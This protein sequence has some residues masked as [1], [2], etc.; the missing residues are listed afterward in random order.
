MRVKPIIILALLMAGFTARAQRAAPGSDTVLKGSTIEVIQSYKPRVKQSPKPEWKPQLPPVDTSRP[1]FS[2][3]VPQQTLYYT[4]NSPPLR[5]LALGK[6]LNELPYQSYVK[7]GGGNRST[8]YADLGTGAIHGEDYETSIHGHHISQEGNIVNQQTSLSGLELAGAK[9]NATGDL[10]A[11]LSGS[12]NR[13]YYYGYDHILHNYSSESVSQAYTSVQL[14]ADMV[15]RKDTS[16]KLDYHPGI[17]ASYY[18]AKYNTNEITASFAA[19]VTYTV[20]KTLALAVNL[21]GA[22]T[23]YKTGGISTANN[24]VMAAPGLKLQFNEYYS[25]HALAGVAYGKGGNI[26]FLPDAEVA[27]TMKDYL[28]KL[29]LGWKANLRQNTYEQLSTE[30]PYLVSAYQVAQT[31]RDEIFGMVQGSLGNHFSYSGRASFWNYTNL[32]TY[33]NDSGDQK[34]FYVRYQDVKALSFQASARYHIA[35]KWSAGLTGEWYSFLQSTDQFVWH[36]PSLSIKGDFQFAVTPKL[37]VSAYGII[38]GGI[39]ARDFAGNSVTLKTIADIG[40]SAEYKII[41]RLSAFVQLNN[42]LNSK[43]QRW[44]GYEVYGFNIYGGLR[45]KF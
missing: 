11:S 32:A 25:A 35:G 29:S 22:V 4:Y 2:T 18:G 7:L 9:H 24:Y 38:L 1:S 6:S 8:I 13:Y 27:F 12:H 28:F 45:L 26:Y 20:N 14:A 31:K 3:D 5:P 15:N 44:M 10:N 37:D 41:P 23:N 30:N 43:Y 17:R 34:A 16:T 19:P 42:L 40:A 39:H 21:E 36:T 33:L